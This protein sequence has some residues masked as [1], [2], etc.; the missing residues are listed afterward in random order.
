MIAETICQKGNRIPIEYR[1]DKEKAILLLK[2]I[3]DKGLVIKNKDVYS[4]AS[5]AGYNI[6]YYSCSDMFSDVESVTYVGEKPTYDMSIKDGN[7]YV[8]NGIICHNTTNLPKETSVEDVAKI[9]TEAWK[10]KCKGVTIYREGSR[11]GILTTENTTSNKIVKTNA[12]KRPKKLPCD[13]HHITVKGQQ[14]F[15]LVGLYENEPYEVF[16][17]KNGIISK[18]VKKGFIEKVKR[19]QYKV[20]FENGFEIDNL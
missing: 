14:Y 1:K 13:V 15:V 12:P 4:L 11:I 16:A 2:E 17:D 8:A 7:S 20:V 3:K 10:M 5:W 9:Y 18:S 6:D 19:G